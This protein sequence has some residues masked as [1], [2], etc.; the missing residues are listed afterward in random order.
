[1]EREDFDD[2]EVEALLSSKK[3]ASYEFSFMG[4]G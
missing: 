3:P 2:E 1:V 4:K